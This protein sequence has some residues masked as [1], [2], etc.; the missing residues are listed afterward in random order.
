MFLG[1][2]RLR[3]LG[4]AWPF[5]SFSPFAEAFERGEAEAITMR[6]QQL[7]DPPPVRARH[8]HNLHPFLVAVS[9]EPRLRALC[10]FTSHT[11]LGFRQS[12]PDMQSRALA[13][14][15]ACVR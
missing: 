3:H 6:W 14:V 12:V 10:P 2:A 1:G 11:D 8:L 5:V 9:G 4:A 13:W 15:R 7:L